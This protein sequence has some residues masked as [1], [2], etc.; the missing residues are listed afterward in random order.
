MGADLDAKAMSELSNFLHMGGHGP[1]IWSAWALT[2]LALAVNAVLAVREKRRALH[3]AQ[4]ESASDS[5]PPPIESES[6]S[7]RNESRSAPPQ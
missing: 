7:L 6:E 3:Q 4:N 1:Y 2:A 5:E